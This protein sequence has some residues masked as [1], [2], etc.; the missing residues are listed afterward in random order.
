MQNYLLCQTACA[1]PKPAC[2]QQPRAVCVHLQGDSLVP[3]HRVEGLASQRKAPALYSH[4][5]LAAIIRPTLSA[6][7]LC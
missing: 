5:V 7:R 3:A 2:T 1:Q 6:R 4:E